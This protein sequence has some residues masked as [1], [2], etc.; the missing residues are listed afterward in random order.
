MYLEPI[1]NDLFCG[2]FQC[3]AKFLQDLSNGLEYIHALMRKKLEDT[4]N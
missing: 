2:T 3:M 1:G 4:K